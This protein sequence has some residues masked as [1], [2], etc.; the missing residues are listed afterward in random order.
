MLNWFIDP[1]NGFG[2]RLI[3]VPS[4]EEKEYVQK[5]LRNMGTRLRIPPTEMA[6]IHR[7]V[8]VWG[9]EVDRQTR[10][11]QIQ[12]V[13]IDNMDTILARE[14]RL[15]LDPQKFTFSMTD[16]VEIERIVLGWSTLKEV[17]GK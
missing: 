14:L 11:M 12:D 2:R 16:N 15:H 4:H 13:W 10:G 17:K 6:T 5:R 3:V 1:F 9:P 7:R 8:A